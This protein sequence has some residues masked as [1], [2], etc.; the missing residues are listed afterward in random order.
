MNLSF[1]FT[2]VSISVTFSLRRT[3]G[4]RGLVINVLSS[5]IQLD[6]SVGELL[7]TQFRMKPSPSSQPARGRYADQWHFAG[8]GNAKRNTNDG[9][10]SQVP[11]AIAIGSRGETEPSSEKSCFHRGVLVRSQNHASR[12]GPKGKLS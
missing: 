10:D 11:R 3:I 5:S 8:I 12:R 6:V 4:K 7:L 9:P 2:T 1:V